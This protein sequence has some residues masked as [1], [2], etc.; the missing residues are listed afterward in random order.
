MKPVKL[1]FLWHQHQPYYKK[2]NEF[3]LPWV[4]FHA[5]KD[6]LDLL[7]LL[8]E[9]PLIKQN[10]NLVPSLLLQ[11]NEYIS[12]EVQDRVQILSSKHPTELSL[13]EK[14]EILSQFFICNYD[15]LIKPNPRYLELYQKAKNFD[16]ALENFNDHDWLDLQVWYNL[17]WIG[18]ISRTKSPFQRFFIKGEAFTQEEKILL[19][20]EQRKLMAEIIPTLQR[21]YNLNQI[22]ISVSSFY[23]PILPLLIDNYIAKESN[24]NLQ[25][26]IIPFRYTDDA[27]LQVSMGKQY[28]QRYLNIDLNGYW[29]SEGALST[30]AL[31]L[32]SEEGFKW[33]ATDPKLLFKTLPEVKPSSQFFPY[34]FS[35]EGK[36]IWVF[37]RDIGLSDAI[38]FTYQKWDTEDAVEDFISR[39]LKIRQQI[40]SDFGEGALDFACISVVLDGENCWEFYKENGIPFLRS[41][42][43]RISNEPLIKTV[44]FSESLPNNPN[45]TFRIEKIAPGSWINA[46]FDTWIGQPQKQVAWDWL[47]KVRGIIE[48]FKTNYEIYQKALQMIMIAEGSDWFWWYGDD[49]F[50]PNKK[51]FDAL[52][53]WYLQKILEVVGEPVPQELNFPIGELYKTKIFIPA[54]K[55]ITENQ[56]RNLS[57]DLGWGR[58]QSRYAISSMHSSNELISDIFFG[59]GKVMFYIGLKLLRQMDQND[60]ISIYFYSPIEAKIEVHNDTISANFE[61]LKGIGRVVFKFLDN[62]ILGISMDSFFGKKSQYDGGIIEF[63]IVN[64]SQQTEFHFP[65]DGSFTYIVV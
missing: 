35:S 47:A 16:F 30:A 38:G 21:L 32:I 17:T 65:T 27:K 64:I 13:E 4:R 19:L 18:N 20:S 46:S 9:F 62:Y 28:V 10:F 59:N 29:P 45:Y 33:T 58:Y 54:S 40:I 51:D 23:H 42:Y 44:T 36:E 7:L 15:N 63:S 11:I 56:F 52:F 2:D 14:K 26:E 43:Q 53:R 31:L 1:A 25:L 8:D 61:K 48:K 3:I 37:F 5:V 50:A 60:I 39:V 24:P 6:Y 57:I 34:L 12:G 49:N 55:K 41:L 22:E